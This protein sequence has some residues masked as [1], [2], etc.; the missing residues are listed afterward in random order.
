[1]PLGSL[2]THAQLVS[3]VDLISSHDLAGIFFTDNHAICKESL[4][5]QERGFLQTRLPRVTW[6]G[7]RESVTHGDEKA[8]LS[9]GQRGT[10]SAGI[11]PDGL[12]GSGME[13]ERNGIPRSQG[14]K[15][16]PRVE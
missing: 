2:E 13:M 1:M 16:C 6:L 7:R 14:E 9:V 10:A 12:C 4:T 11:L 3:R 5:S 15:G 8:L